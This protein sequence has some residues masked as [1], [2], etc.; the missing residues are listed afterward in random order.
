M[1]ELEFIKL[2][3][4]YEKEENE[5]N[6]KKILQSIIKVIKQNKDEYQ[7]FIQ[8]Q[9]INPKFQSIIDDINF[10]LQNNINEENSSSDDVSKIKLAYTKW[11]ESFKVKNQIT[12]TCISIVE[13]LIS[14]YLPNQFEV[15]EKILDIKTDQTYELFKN[16]IK[17]NIR[18]I[19][20]KQIEEYINSEKFEKLN[21]FQKIKKKKELTK[22]TRELINYEFN[23]KKISEVL[24]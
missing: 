16:H 14:Y 21:F 1:F 7:N 2:L 11:E 10:S 20:S 15:I 17:N 19:Y 6:Q 3:N 12:P 13:Q 8:N 18:T 4:E 9:D 5:T 23:Q 24:N 22:L